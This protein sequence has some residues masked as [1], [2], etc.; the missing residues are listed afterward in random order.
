MV[1]ASVTA[2]GDL[3]RLPAEDLVRQLG[4][5]SYAEREA[6]QQ[7]LERR[8]E[9]A[10]AA[11]A[12]AAHGPDLEVCRRCWALL[13]KLDEGRLR[14]EV[15]KPRPIR[16]HYSQAPL[17][18]VLKAIALR[19]GLRIEATGVAGR[20]V[21]V[22]TGEVPFWQAWDRFCDAA[23]LCEPA[24]AD[25]AGPLPVLR[26]AAGSPS[27]RLPVDF[28]GP[29]RVRVRPVTLGAAPLLSALAGGPV[30]G[31]VEV[32]ADP[33]LDLL[34]IDEVRVTRGRDH[35]GLALPLPSPVVLRPLPESPP[36]FTDAGL[37]RSALGRAGRL[38]PLRLA[39]LAPLLPP[40]ELAG[41]VTARLLIRGACVT[42]PEP[43]SAA[44]KTFAGAG[45]TTLTVL[46]AETSEDGDLVLTLR[47]DGLADAEPGG[48]LHRPRPGLVVVR[49]AVGAAL[50]GLELHDAQG[51]PL[52][53]ERLERLGGDGPSVRC[54]VTFPGGCRRRAAGA[55]GTVG[56]PGRGGVRRG[57][58]KA[59]TEGPSHGRTSHDRCR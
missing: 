23:G 15:F 28:D 8:G 14:A 51:R 42:V 12:A 34:G 17:P 21:S 35:A 40:R 19:T 41:V 7:E 44:G 29:L 3:V 49:D 11:L 31:V 26:V 32:W 16:L 25:G 38:V 50:E 20:T 5:S 46:A 39:G 52:P 4:S 22:D 2:G 18:E 48:L 47:L 36:L 10:A 9:A 55:H 45:A 1:V 30:G 58:V 37:S 57:V 33:H 24:P 54:R 13:K 53:R 6:A 59:V 27:A 43:R 56:G